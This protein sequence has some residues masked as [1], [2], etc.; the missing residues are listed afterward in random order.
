M[1]A[2]STALKV[3]SILSLA[4]SM[5]ITGCVGVFSVYEVSDELIASCVRSKGFSEG[6]QYR[7]AEGSRG[8]V[9]RWVLPGGGISERAAIEINSCIEKAVRGRGMP[10][11][12]G[13][14]QSVTSVPTATGRTDTFIYGT[15]PAASRSGSP[16]VGS[17]CRGNVMQGGTGYC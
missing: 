9:D 4:C 8:Y 1:S 17:R 15:P 10:N 3:P 6:T 11:V 16:A 5:A 2:L 14:P 7:V 13:V 12:A